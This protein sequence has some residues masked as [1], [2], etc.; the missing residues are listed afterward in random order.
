MKNLTSSFYTFFFLL[1]VIS[2]GYNDA[3]L[4]PSII[5]DDPDYAH[6]TSETKVF[7]ELSADGKYEVFIVID[8]EVSSIV[9]NVRIDSDDLNFYAGR[10]Y[11]VFTGTDLTTGKKKFYAYNGQELT[12]NSKYDSYTHLKVLN[13][14]YYLIGK[15]NV[16]GTSTLV[17]FYYG[18]LNDLVR[19][20]T[21]NVAVD[22]QG[23]DLLSTIASDDVDT[24]YVAAGKQLISY[25]VREDSFAVE[26]THYRNISTLTYWRDEIIFSDGS[27]FS[28][29][30]DDFEHFD[31]R[32][33][34][35]RIDAKSD[36]YISVI[37][38]NSIRIY[39]NDLNEVEEITGLNANTKTI[40]IED[41]IY[42]TK[43]E[44]NITKLYRWSVS[45]GSEEISSLGENVQV[46]HFGLDGNN[47][48]VFVT[49][50]SESIQT[51]SFTI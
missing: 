2:C 14:E 35:I 31:N 40:V 4:R 6:V 10:G 38:Y 8:G 15:S 13:D 36:E 7:S 29:I 20:N 33:G 24:L 5:Y 16:N 45:T 49:E 34:V 21:T 12:E 39:D 47:L 22:Y 3:T 50:E 9:S 46:S 44:S 25:N 26:K 30:S 48:E 28:G 17:Q 42:Y 27:L 32:Y 18:E 11:A 23:V 51:S 37:T 43:V 41:E 19:F 1:T